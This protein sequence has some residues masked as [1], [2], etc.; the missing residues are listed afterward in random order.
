MGPRPTPD[1]SAGLIP[2]TFAYGSH[3]PG[4]RQTLSCQFQKLKT[5][6]QGRNIIRLRHDRRHRNRFSSVQPT[7]DR[8][9]EM[10][11]SGS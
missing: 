4:V 9:P 5:H 6:E 1:L 7:G 2:G 10:A 11:S 8:F 3:E